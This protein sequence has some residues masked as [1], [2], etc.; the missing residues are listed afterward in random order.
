MTWSLWFPDFQVEIFW[1]HGIERP[2]GRPLLCVA[3]K[4]WWEVDVKEFEGHAHF[5]GG[6]EIA[7]GACHVYGDTVVCMCWTQGKTRAETD[8]CS[9]DVLFGLQ[10]S[11]TGPVSFRCRPVGGK[12]LQQQEHRFCFQLCEA[13]HGQWSSVKKP[14]LLTQISLGWLDLLILICSD[15]V[16]NIFRFCHWRLQT[17]SYV[18]ELPSFGC[19]NLDAPKSLASS[20]R[21]ATTAKQP[22]ERMAV[23]LVEEPAELAVKLAEQPMQESAKNQDRFGWGLWGF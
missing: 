13:P 5:L 3:H 19:R 16:G 18:L 4:A 23:K 10:F 12:H 2:E 15:M 7:F 21:M 17:F 6:F 20:L 14:F 1:K 9:R 22:G 11:L 8:W